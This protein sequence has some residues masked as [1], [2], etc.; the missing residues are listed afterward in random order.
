MLISIK[1]GEIQYNNSSDKIIA[2]LN[3]KSLD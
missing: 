3:D 1:I 2:T